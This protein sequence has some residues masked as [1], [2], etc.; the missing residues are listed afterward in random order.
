MAKR[1]LA[2]RVANKKIRRSGKDNLENAYSGKSN[3]YRKE[4]ESWHIWDYRFWGEP[5]W[6]AESWRNIEGELWENFI[7]ESEAIDYGNSV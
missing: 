6:R 2:K 3:D 5:I 1:N 4:N 7:R